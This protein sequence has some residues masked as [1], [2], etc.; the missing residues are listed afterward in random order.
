MMNLSRRIISTR[1]LKKRSQTQGKKHPVRL[2]GRQW[3]ASLSEFVVTLPVLL[4]LG[5]GTMQAALLYN[6]KNTVTYATFEAARKGA[7]NHAQIAPMQAELGLRIAPVFG[8][9]GSPEKAM[10][11]ITRG[12]LEAQDPRYTKIEVLNPSKEAFD[13]FGVINDDGVLEIPNSNLRFRDRS[14]KPHSKVNI[15]DANLL[16][17]KVTYAYALTIPLIDRL[18]PA[19]MTK[20][21]PD[22]AAYYLLG[23]IPVTAVATLRMQSAAYADGNHFINES[24]SGSGAIP[25]LGGDSDNTEEALADESNYDEDGNA[26]EGLSDETA[27]ADESVSKDP[28]EEIHA[29]S[30]SD[31]TQVENTGGS[32]TGASS[33][34]ETGTTENVNTGTESASNPSEETHTSTEEGGLLD[35]KV[36][37]TSTWEDPEYKIVESD[38]WFD[39]IVN[40]SDNVSAVY[41]IVEDFFEGL[42]EGFGNQI[43][44]LV[45]I[46]TDPSILWDMAKA[47]VKDPVGF[48]EQIIEGLVKDVK[49]LIQCGP[50]DIGRIVGENL[51]PVVFLKALSTVAGS[52]RL[53]KYAD[54]VEGRAKDKDGNYVSDVNTEIEGVNCVINSFVA[55]TQVITP[56]GPVAIETLRKGDMVYSRSDLSFGSK[57]QNIVDRTSR[58][59]PGYHRIT[60]E[61]GV[62]EASYNHPFWVQGKGWV[63]AENLKEWDAVA[64]LKGGDILIKNNEYI[65]EETRVFNFTIANTYSYFVGDGGLWVHNCKKKGN[66]SEVNDLMDEAFPDKE[67]RDNYFVYSTQEGKVVIS[68]KDASIDERYEYSDGKVQKATNDIDIPAKVTE[69]PSQSRA[70]ID[71]NMEI[72]LKL[73]V[74]GKEVTIKG[75][76]EKVMEQLSKDRDS[77]VKARNDAIQVQDDAAIRDAIIDM[78]NA[79]QK[80][81]EVASQAYMKKNFPNAH[82]LESKL[83]GNGNQGEFDQIYIDKD[84]GRLIIVEAKGGNATWGSKQANGKQVQQG[85]REYMESVIDN[86]KKKLDDADNDKISIS[87]TEHADLANTVQAFKDA[88]KNIDYYGIKQKATDAGVSSDISIFKFDL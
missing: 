61:F 1:S 82:A 69:K 9:D 29:D 13:D 80:L 39:S 40:A 32:G 73:I 10:A 78:R 44:D 35:V 34:S 16:K 20:I 71:A 12:M 7:V 2:K 85:S 33:G 43:K 31:E 38:G 26:N 30:V 3:G 63:D 77:A 70:D 87:A 41:N 46:I 56:G 52:T 19:I 88:G 24:N 64:A 4:L 45:T 59:A 58:V 75:S 72:D 81:G 79:S 23:R 42:V 67:V 84:S 17:I 51:N 53:A 15:Q 18:L 50:K 47:A 5:L 6:A 25:E 27:T 76:Y 22:N 48:V 83:P 86:Y 62:I 14:V 8:G 57:P 11:A 36:E 55:G 28:S 65:E 49:T 66:V 60:T 37:C 74:N 21:D 68:R 54:V